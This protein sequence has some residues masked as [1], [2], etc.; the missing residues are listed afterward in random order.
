[1]DAVSYD[2]ALAAQQ[3]TID[4]LSFQ[5]AELHRKIA[6]VVQVGTVKSFDAQKGAV[7]DVGYETHNVPVAWHS[8]SGA[9]WAPL[10][11]G[12]Q[13]TMLCPSGD[14]ANGF[15]LPGGFHDQNPAPSTDAGTDI[16]AQRGSAQQPNRLR[17]TD[18]GA[19]L[20]AL[21]N[22]IAVENGKVT[23]TADKV[24]LAGTVYLGGSDASNPASMKGTVDS[25]GNADES[26]LATKVFV[27]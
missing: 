23:I 13:V 6:G 20:E 5:I 22:A 2:A 18:N 7:L 24:I 15:V 10:K 1:M 26:N 27:K 11:V 12:Q 16:R 8:G 17:T 9:D 14:P 21:G 3:R 4:D 19:Y 25:G